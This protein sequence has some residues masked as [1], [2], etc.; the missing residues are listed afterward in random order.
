MPV[1]LPSCFHHKAA[2]SEPRPQGAAEADAAAVARGE[3][4]DGLVARNYTVCVYDIYTIYSYLP[5]YGL[6]TLDTLCNVLS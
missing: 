2:A 5:L 4:Y 3:F 1:T 6:Y